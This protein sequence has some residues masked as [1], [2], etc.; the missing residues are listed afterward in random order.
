M[1]LDVFYYDFPWKW[2]TIGPIIQN[3]FSK[4]LVASLYVF[5]FNKMSAFY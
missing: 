4:L 5:V 1:W 2:N 3:F